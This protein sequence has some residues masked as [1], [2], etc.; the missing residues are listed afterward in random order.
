MIKIN[1][2]K[3][4]RMEKYIGWLDNLDIIVFDIET[5]STTPNKDY[6]RLIEI[7]AV[8]LNH[9]N[10][11]IIDRFDELIDPEIKISNTTQNLTGITQDMLKGKRKYPEVV[12]DFIKF[13]SGDVVV[14]GH[15]IS[16]FD[17]R[18]VNYFANIIGMTFAPPRVVDTL[19]MSKNTDIK[20]KCVKHKLEYLA[21]YY[22][23]DDPSHH[24]AMNDVIVNVDILNILHQKAKSQGF[25]PVFVDVKDNKQATI[26]G[27]DKRQERSINMVAPEV[28]SINP[29]T[30]TVNERTYRRLYVKL[31]AE[32]QYLDAFYDFDSYVWQVKPNEKFNFDIDW[33]SVETS[34]AKIKKFPDKKMIKEFE[35]FH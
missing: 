3:R 2:E 8:K 22:G 6:G 25:K 26:F 19:F 13:C 27:A 1:K 30:K 10:Y 23:I 15:N 31:F 20:E 9:K 7:S 33:D 12:R 11:E 34:V 21:E 17:I 29:W 5:T 16:T 18:F 28:R 4:E 35:N 24:R 32:G 14:A